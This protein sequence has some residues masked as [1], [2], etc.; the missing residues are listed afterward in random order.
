MSEGNNRAGTSVRASTKLMHQLHRK[1]WLGW[2]CGGTH[3]QTTGTSGGLGIIAQI[4]ISL[5]STFW[6]NVVRELV[7]R[8]FF[9]H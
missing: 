5:F 2:F 6:S 8:F 1:G 9:G 3:A 4:I 7:S